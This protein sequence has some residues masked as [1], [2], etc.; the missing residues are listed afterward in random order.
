[1]AATYIFGPVYLAPFPEGDNG[2]SDGSISGDDNKLIFVIGQSWRSEPD[3]DGHCHSWCDVSWIFLGV[4]YVCECEL[5]AFEWCD[6]YSLDVFW[7]I[8]QFDLGLVDVHGL[9]LSEP[10]LLRLGSKLVLLSR[11]GGEGGCVGDGLI[12][13]AR[14]AGE[15]DLSVHAICDLL[16][17]DLLLDVEL[18]QFGRFSHW[19]W[20]LCLRQ[21]FYNGSYKWP[22]TDAYGKG[23]DFGE[24][25]W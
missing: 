22:H 1:M 10:H 2:D 21:H 8:D 15:G 9:V 25:F 23:G 3:G 19:G 17:L 12:E 6:F 11:G 7:I 14:V 4:S 16:V 18:W 20:F 13:V 24:R 5:S